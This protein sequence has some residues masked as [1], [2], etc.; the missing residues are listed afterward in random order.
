MA[1]KGTRKEHL[2]DRVERLAEWQRLERED[3][4]RNLYAC[5]R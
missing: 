3:I 2:G 5:G 4:K 1:E